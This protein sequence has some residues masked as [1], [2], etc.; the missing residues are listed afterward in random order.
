MSCG[1]MTVEKGVE[2]DFMAVWRIEVE[3]DVKVEIVVCEVIGNR[4]G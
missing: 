4:C 3:V 2:F 1:T